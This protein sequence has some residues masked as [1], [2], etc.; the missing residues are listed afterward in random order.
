[1]FFYL[2]LAH[3][4]CKSVPIT[5]Q[6]LGDTSVKMTRKL[7]EMHPGEIHELSIV[8]NMKIYFPLIYGVASASRIESSGQKA[9]N[10]HSIKMLPASAIVV[11]PRPNAAVHPCVPPS[12]H[13][14]SRWAFHYFEQSATEK[15]RSVSIAQT[16]CS[17]DVFFFI[18][19][20]NAPGKLF[21]FI[22]MTAS[23]ASLDVYWN[24]NR[25]AE[26][27]WLRLRPNGWVSVYI[28]LV[29]R[30]AYASLCA[31]M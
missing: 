28:V 2:L 8:G 5:F 14:R 15:E 21:C 19:S 30:A 11:G 23:G 18:S 31:S 17:S 9:V 10:H 13:S 4:A 22:Q 27:K 7:A 29:M 12:A 20:V 6:V 16:K 26:V 3:L 24:K 25:A 1:M